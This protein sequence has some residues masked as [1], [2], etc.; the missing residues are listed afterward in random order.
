MIPGAGRGSLG[1]VALIEALTLILVQRVTPLQ[2]Q[3][4]Y[5]WIFADT[6]ADTPVGCIFFDALGTSVIALLH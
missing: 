5:R 3:A 4:G 6:G 2:I 1:G